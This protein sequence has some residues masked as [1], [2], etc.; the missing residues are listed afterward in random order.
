MAARR[1]FLLCLCVGAMTSLAVAC[2]SS[3]DGSSAAAQSESGAGARGPDGAVGA[4][5]GAGD[6]SG[7]PMIRFGKFGGSY[8]VPIPD[9]RPEL[10][11]AAHYAVARLEWSVEERGNVKLE[12]LLPH[13]LVGQRLK[14]EFEGPFDRTTGVGTLVGDVG[15]AECTTT[16]NTLSC[17]EVMRGLLPLAIDPDVISDAAAVEYPG[18]AEHRLQISQI[19]AVDPLGI[20]HIDLTNQIEAD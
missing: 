10:K 8:E 11:A 19:F 13:G 5:A 7:T 20:A 14:V 15:T 1:L 16:G 4:D 3:E 18:P 9:D 2:G 17:F 12:Y 6:G